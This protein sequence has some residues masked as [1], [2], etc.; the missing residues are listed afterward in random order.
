MRAWCLPLLVAALVLVSGCIRRQS[1]VAQE[2]DPLPDVTRFTMEPGERAFYEGIIS[3]HFRGD[4]GEWMVT[5][6]FTLASLAT[7]QQDAAAFSVAQLWEF[8][9]PDVEGADAQ[10]WGRRGAHIDCRDFDLNRTTE[11]GDL[12]NDLRPFDLPAPPRAEV[13]PGLAFRGTRTGAERNGLPGPG[14]YVAVDCEVG[15]EALVEGTPCLPIE[16]APADELPLE[17][18]SRSF[19]PE[20]GRPEKLTLTQFHEQI[21]VDRDCGWVVKYTYESDR[22]GV[23]YQGRVAE[24]AST[25]TVSLV[26]R[27]QLAGEELQSHI[28]QIARLREIRRL[29]DHSGLDGTVDE[30]RKLASAGAEQLASF[31]REYPNGPYAAVLPGLER[32]LEARLGS[33][34]EQAAE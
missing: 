1:S 2:P 14:T 18:R 17:L 22:T 27:D 23:Y 24:C 26:S 12:R 15:D 25:C 8:G 31:R 11:A 5:E 13:R 9:P 19:L 21:W 6:S 3:R 28:D 16:V 4:D 29:G 32:S 20:G 30:R 7:E 10:E 33:L 34:A